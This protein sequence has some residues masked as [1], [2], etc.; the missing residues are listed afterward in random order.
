MKNKGEKKISYYNKEVERKTKTIEI[1][2]NLVANSSQTEV[3]IKTL[4]QKLERQIKYVRDG[5]LLIRELGIIKQK[6]Q[7]KSWNLKE[8]K[9]EKTTLKKNKTKGN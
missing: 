8:Y 4:V 6:I 1:L 2:S 5:K 7:K 3:E 9:Q